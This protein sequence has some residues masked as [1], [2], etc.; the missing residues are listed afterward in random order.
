VKAEKPSKFLIFSEVNAI[1]GK[2]L[3][4][5]KEAKEKAPASSPKKN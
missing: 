3:A 5:A 4:E 2:K 1:D